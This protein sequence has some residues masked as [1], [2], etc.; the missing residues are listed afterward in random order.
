MLR[1]GRGS[2]L[3]MGRVGL[4]WVGSGWEHEIFSHWVG[5]V[6]SGPVVKMSEKCVV[7]VQETEYSLTIISNDM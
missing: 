5:R 7:Y 3:S 1:V 6:V 4:G 2:G